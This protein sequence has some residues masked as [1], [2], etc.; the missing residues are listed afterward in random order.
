MADVVVIAGTADARQVIERLLNKNI[1]V[2]ATVVTSFGSE[3]LSERHGLSVHEGRLACEGITG[4]IFREKAKCL[5][6]AS[7]PFAKDVTLN[8]LQACAA[9]QV[10]YL[11]FEREVTTLPVAEGIIFSGDFIQAAQQAACHKGNI[12]LTIG[13]NN[14]EV[15][16]QRI[17]DYKERL[18][19]RVL[20]MRAVI[21]KCEAAGLTAANIIAIKGPFSEE[22]NIE[23]IKHCHAEVLVTKDSGKEGGVEEKLSAARKAGIDVVLI[24]RP[25]ID[26]KDRVS[27]INEVV[28][29]VERQLR[30]DRTV[31]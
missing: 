11:R 10:P 8:A 31:V 26:Y 18:F 2:A 23:M 16:T 13:S 25:D 28:E 21:A 7:H 3:L 30:Q 27:S 12:L 5:V 17:P 14:L 6:D 20:P 24:K 4:L 9:A 1:S 22:M 19:V 15:F 29:F